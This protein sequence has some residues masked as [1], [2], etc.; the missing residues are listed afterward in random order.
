MNS[1]D[2]PFTQFLLDPVAYEAAVTWWKNMIIRVA[3]KSGSH[4]RDRYS[5]TLPSGESIRDGNPIVA[6]H[7]D[8][9]VGI[10]IIQNKPGAFV[11]FTAYFGRYEANGT[12]QYELVIA[13]VLSEETAALA[14]QL[15]A[16]WGTGTKSRSD[17]EKLIGEML[18]GQN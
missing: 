2:F 13:C 5:S 1:S 4:W 17:I 9:G 3:A 15:I 16:A 7:S 12:E 6:V 10:R 18:K 8:Q 14:E 11:R